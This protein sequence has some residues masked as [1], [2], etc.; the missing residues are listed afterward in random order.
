M[1]FTESI[2]T[3][4]SKYATFKGRATRSEFWWFYLF[5]LILGWAASIAGAVMFIGGGVEE[6]QF[7]ADILSSFV[8]L[9]LMV[10]TMAVS[11]RRLHDIGKSGWWNFILLTVIGIFLVLYWW[12]KEGDSSSNRFSL[13][14]E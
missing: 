12:A 5:S 13:E 4:F 10:P 11:C 14:I 1:T 9:A 6:M 8:T 7:G 3:C 2:A